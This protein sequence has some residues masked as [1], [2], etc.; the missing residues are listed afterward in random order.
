[1]AKVKI[2]MSLDSDV[3]DD[4]NAMSAAT[5]IPKSRLVERAIK[6]EMQR[7]RDVPMNVADASPST[8][9]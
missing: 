8:D 6:N 5:M 4:L 3:V 9:R 7:M 2:T 1:M